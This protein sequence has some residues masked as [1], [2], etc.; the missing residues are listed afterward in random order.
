MPT[1]NYK[2]SKCGTVFDFFQSIN[3]DKLTD[4][5][6]CKS[7]NSI[8]RLITGGTGMIF[9]GDGFYITDYKKNKKEE[10]RSKKEQKSKENKKENKKGKKE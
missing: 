2:C 6:K 1:Y 10:G 3:D 8:D 4:C 5:L 9:K 7:K